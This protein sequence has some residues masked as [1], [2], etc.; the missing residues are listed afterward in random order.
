MWLKAYVNDEYV[1][2]L[3]LDGYAKVDGKLPA[4]TRGYYAGVST[5]GGNTVDWDDI[6]N[7]TPRRR[8]RRDRFRRR[9]HQQ[10]DNL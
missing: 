10:R 4:I 6:K 1:A 7:A 9:H 3:E 8:Q 5:S 2:E